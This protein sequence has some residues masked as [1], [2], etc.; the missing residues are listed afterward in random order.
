MYELEP[1]S[2]QEL[3]SWDRLIEPC[4]GREFFHRGAWLEFLAESRNAQIRYWTIRDSGTIVGYFVGGIVRKG[5]FRI[6]G[7]PL[8]GWG[9]NAMGPVVR[10]DFDPQ[11]FLAA[12]DHTARQEGISMV[13]LESALLPETHM[14]E[15]GYNPVRDKTLILELSSQDPDVMFQRIHRTARYQIRRAKRNGLTVEDCNDVGIVRESYDQWTEVL[16]RKGLSPYYP[17]RWVRLAFEKLKPLDLLFALCVRDPN[18][19]PIATGLF[20]HDDKTLYYSLCT[21]SRIASWHL[22]PNDLLHWTAMEMAARRG[23][24]VYNMCGYG[25]F[26]AQFGG[27]LQ[28]TVRWH[29][30]YNRSA[31]VA[32]WTYERL[33]N[34]RI[35]LRGWWNRKTT[36]ADSG[37]SAEE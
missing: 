4:E 21:G 19:K 7:S 36:P 30:F 27:D 14:D 8:R 11:R 18:G 28:E 20:P 35:R 25:H 24:R 9:T 5:P 33:Y 31:K 3:R 13:E 12:L 26:R 15:L 29:K 16:A 22:F 37:A 10:S 32:R 17:E 1:L 34:S 23:L 6:L 2:D